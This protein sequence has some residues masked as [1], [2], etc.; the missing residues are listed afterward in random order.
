MKFS[1]YNIERIRGTGLR[2]DIRSIFNSNYLWTEL[3]EEC[4]DPALTEWELDFKARKKPYHFVEAVDK[5]T[6]NIY[7]CILVEEIPYGRK[8]KNKKNQSGNQA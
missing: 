2:T 8:A 4:D 5:K 1:D 6:G 7:Y 3:Y